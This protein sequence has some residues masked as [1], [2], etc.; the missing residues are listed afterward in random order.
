VGSGDILLEMRRRNGMRNYWRVDLEWDNDG[1]Q[2]K[3]K[4]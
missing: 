4:E 3:I 2:K 1:V